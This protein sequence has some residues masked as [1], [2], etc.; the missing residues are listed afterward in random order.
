[1]TKQ[2]FNAFFI[3]SACFFECFFYYYANC[4]SVQIN[5]LPLEFKGNFLLLSF[6]LEFLL[7]L[8]VEHK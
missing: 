2:N 3:I 5:F 7:F 6:Y 1:M 4:E 8:N